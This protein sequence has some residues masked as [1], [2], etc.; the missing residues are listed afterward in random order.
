MG[1]TTR[2]TQYTAYV[3]PDTGLARIGHYDL[4][5][6]TIQ[7]LS[8][9]SGTPVRDLYQV[10]AAGPSHIIADGEALSAK[11]VKLL[12]TISGR[13]VLAVGK[14]YMEHAKEFNSSGYDSSDKTDRPSHPV[15]FTKRATSIIADGEDIL[16]HPEF[17]QT[18]DY[19]GE[20][21]VII[22][23]TAFRVEEA[24]AWD[25]VWGYTII[26]DMTAR[27]RQRDHKQF[28]IGKSPD[29]FCPIGPVAVSRDN[30]PAVLKVETHVNGEL[31][32]SANTEHLI[33]SIPT[34]VKP[35]SEGQTL[36]PGDVIAT[37]T[38][39]KKPPV[40]LQSGDEVAV[41]VINAGDIPGPRYLA[42]AREIAKPEGDLVAGITRFADGPEE[43]TEIR[44][45]QDCYF[46]DEEMT[47]CVDEAHKLG[48][49]LC[50][51]ARATD[52]VKMCVKHGV[53]V[54]YHGS[55]IDDEG[56]NSTPRRASADKLGMEMLEKEREKYMVVPA[57]NWLYATTYEAEAFGYT[58]EA[59][60]KA[61]YKRE[62][63]RADC[64]LVDG[65][66]LQDISILQDHE[67]L[68]I[69]IINGRV[70]KAGRREY[71][72]DTSG[73]LSRGIPHHLTEDF[74][75]KRPAMQKSY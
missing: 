47:A 52:S 22:G 4:G 72:R 29:T 58:Y 45:A 19:E 56:M 32:Q 13:D 28:F 25:Y 75:E 18:L 24:D 62:L 30:L 42:N 54:I 63:D 21:G 37:G 64:I 27:E 11:D 67:R 73:S 66:P 46:N 48:K 33:F 7:P 55:Y 35:I 39:R 41:S 15:I 31:R 70:H 43:I 36:Q 71:I 3:H 69:I 40:F 17:S 68:S 14:N 38:L 26:N 74:P 8:F 5:Q 2:L 20:I 9:K 57:I 50:A 65:D 53:D 61:G 1:S 51:H 16:P 49:R 44:S 6:G 34:L 59:A 10:I 60:E 12:P 23:K